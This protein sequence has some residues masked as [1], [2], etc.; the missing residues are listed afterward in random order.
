MKTILS[1][2]L[3]LWIHKITF[4]QQIM[5]YNNKTFKTSEAIEAQVSKKGFAFYIAEHELREGRNGKYELANPNKMATHV[6]DENRPKSLSLLLEVEFVKGLKFPIEPK[7]SVYIGVSYGGNQYKNDKK[8]LNDLD[9]NKEKLN[10][11]T[12]NSKAINASF[13]EK[14][15]LLTQKFQ[16]GELSIE[17][18]SAQMT[19]LSSP[20]LKEIESF[21]NQGLLDFEE[22]KEVNT[23]SIF[24]VDD[25][26]L[27]HSNAI[28]GTLHI[29][30][31]NKDE[32][33]ATFKGNHMVECIER[34][35][36]SSRE[37]EAKCRAFKSK[38]IDGIRLL[39]EGGVT[40]NI[41]V[42]LKN[43]ED[44]R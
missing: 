40:G 5:S 4:G 16:A 38:Y 35:A 34:R 39:D 32:F 8:Y 15:K 25:Y 37:E 17:E 36:A 9:K 19:A 23:Y 21:D 10:T 6:Y 24:Y 13:T 1:I 42:R 11:T 26:D 14:S 43:F 7:D 28:S 44:F 30:R 3:L 29:E 20:M 12:Q 31:F 41:N 2:I 33:V 18:F 22:A 27:I